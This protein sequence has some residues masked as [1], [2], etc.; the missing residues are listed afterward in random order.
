MKTN[1]DYCDSIHPCGYTGSTRPHASRHHQMRRTAASLQP[2][3]SVGLAERLSPGDRVGVPVGPGQAYI[4]GSGL[5]IIVL[6]DLWASASARGP[7]EKLAQ[8]AQLIPRCS[9]HAWKGE[10]GGA[11]WPMAH[12]EPL[13]YLR[14]LHVRVVHD[15]PVCQGDHRPKGTD[16]LRRPFQPV[17]A[18][19]RMVRRQLYNAMCC[20]TGVPCVAY[21]KECPPQGTPILQ[22]LWY[23]LTF[24]NR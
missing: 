6:E 7:R 11:S 24:V 17:Q 2:P 15:R 9:Q 18:E 1:Y 13:T 21:L 12:G 14:S 16:H 5:A 10:G 22:R 20:G 3:L 19:G 8:L 4:Q 23:V